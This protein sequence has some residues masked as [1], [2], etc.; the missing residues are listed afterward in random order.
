MSPFACNDRG[1]FAAAVAAAAVVVLCAFYF[2]DV[3]NNRAEM[4]VSAYGQDLF[5]CPLGGI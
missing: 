4:S 1:V 5:G 2:A 3:E